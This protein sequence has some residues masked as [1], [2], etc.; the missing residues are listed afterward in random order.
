[1][2]LRDYKRH[3]FKICTAYV[4]NQSV[5]NTD[6]LVNNLLRWA[7]GEGDPYNYA[8]SNTVSQVEYCSDRMNPGRAKAILV[9]MGDQLAALLSRNPQQ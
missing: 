9:L 2:K 3:T 6:R 7:K 4:A 1:M 5:K 8:N